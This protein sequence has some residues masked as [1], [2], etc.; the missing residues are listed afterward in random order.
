MNEECQEKFLLFLINSD[1]FDYS[2]IVIL[3]V[4]SLI[5]GTVLKNNNLR[6]A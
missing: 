6:Q 3:T 4:I 1:V 2:I 5:N